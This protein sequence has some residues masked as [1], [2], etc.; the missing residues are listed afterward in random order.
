MK[1]VGVVMGSDSDLGVVEKAVNC[2]EKYG[3]ECEVRVLSA[4]RT[5][6]EAAEFARSA[7]G[8]GFGVIIAAA[9]K[10]A[11]LPGV[12]AAFTIL[13]VNRGD[14]RCRERRSFGDTDPCRDR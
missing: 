7:R 14:R 8:N 1:K 3:V 4:H 11:H 6:V 2:L 5:P 10:A 12:L 13:P 9:G